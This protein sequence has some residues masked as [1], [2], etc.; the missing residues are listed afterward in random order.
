MKI[1]KN[2]IVFASVLTIILIFLISY[3]FLIMGDDEG[4]N[5]NLKQT[6]VPELEEEQKDYDS[7]LDAIND[8]KKVRE[9]NA[10][11]IYD[12][13]LIDSLGFYDP[14]LGEKEKARI[15]DSIYKVSRINYSDRT[16]ENIGRG[17]SIPNVI[18]E[19][20]SAEIK[21]DIQIQA[22]ELSFE[23]ERFFASAPLNNEASILGGTDS[24]IYA[25]VD[26]NQVVKI[27]TRLRMRLIK[28]A[29][30]NNKRIQ[31]NTLIYGFISF[32]PNRALIAIENVNHHP[33]NLKA[34]DLADGS[35]GIYV[36][37]SFREEATNEVLDDMVQDIN[38]PSVPQIRGVAKVFRRN[39][40]SVK[41]TVLHNYKLILKPKL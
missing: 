8:L 22:N 40:R 18:L 17:K 6:L 14:D 34:Y 13:K 1:E 33:T 16:Y 39:N 3:S 2:K 24:E 30:I 15:V 35:E 29:T 37:N 19:V 32:Q 9:T 11:S 27:H 26:G 31:K 20:D 38:I 7:K 23:H 12:E 36:E 28:T 21:R 5:E 10:P 4:D 25:V 41:V